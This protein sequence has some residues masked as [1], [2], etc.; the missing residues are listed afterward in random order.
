M[1]FLK[2][3]HARY[4]SHKEKELE[5][6]LANPSGYTWTI[7]TTDNVKIG[8]IEES[9]YLKAKFRIDLNWNT[10]I[11]QGLNYLWV[12]WCSLAKL[13]ISF[14]LILMI[15]SLLAAFTIPHDELST[16]TLG[17][18]LVALSEHKITLFNTFFFTSV[19]Y[20]M[21]LIGLRQT[22]PGYK[23]YRALHLKRELAQH[24]PNIANASGYNIGGWKISPTHA[25]SQ[26]E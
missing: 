5:K 10:K 15:V 9:D 24:V 3:I 25:A 26:S 7:F 2:N 1:N 18:I 8:N 12:I 17:E 23:N 21:V 19:V 16:I 11:L 4:V 14:P 6:A 13:I 22:P 20:V